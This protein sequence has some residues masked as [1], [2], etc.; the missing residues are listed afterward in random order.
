[1]KTIQFESLWMEPEQPTILMD[2]DGLG[3]VR[4]EAAV[5]AEVVL[6]RSDPHQVE[7]VEHAITCF[8]VTFSP[9]PTA[10]RSFSHAR[11]HK[12]ATITESKSINKRMMAMAVAAMVR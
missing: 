7:A 12:H 4:E 1:V 2:R 8:V 3:W 6:A 9:P 11:R 5:T 10:D